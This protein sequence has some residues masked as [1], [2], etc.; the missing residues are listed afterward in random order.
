MRQVALKGF[1]NPSKLGSDLVPVHINTEREKVVQWLQCRLM[2]QKVSVQVFAPP[3]TPWV[4]SVESLNL[5][6]SQVPICTLGLIAH[7][8]LI[9]VL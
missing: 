8:S 2:T 3:Q 9:G 6:V 1:K 7:P 5:S 4:V